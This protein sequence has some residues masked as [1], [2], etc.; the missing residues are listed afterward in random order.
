MVLVDL[1][2]ACV[3]GGAGG[4]QPSNHTGGRPGS[5]FGKPA[6]KGIDCVGPCGR[7]V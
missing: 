4:G 5:E 6:A 2:F 1:W 7:I 3:W